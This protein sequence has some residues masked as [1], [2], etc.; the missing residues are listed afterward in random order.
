MSR[1]R[2]RGYESY[3]MGHHFIHEPTHGPYNAIL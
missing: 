3:G 1:K 2:K